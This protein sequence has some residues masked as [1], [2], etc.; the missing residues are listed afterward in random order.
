MNARPWE[1]VRKKNDTKRKISTMVDNY[2]WYIYIYLIKII[3]EFTLTWDGE[4]LHILFRT[5]VQK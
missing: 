2:I 5:H 3:T 1:A 4:L